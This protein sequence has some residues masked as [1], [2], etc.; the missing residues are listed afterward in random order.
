MRLNLEHPSSV[1]F[2][3]AVS[4]EEIRVGKRVIR[5]SVIIG[6]QDIIPDWPVASTQQI[7]EHHLAP[8]LE[9]EP[10]IVLLGTGRH[11]VFPGRE[12]YGVFLGRRIGLEVMGTAA[13]CRTFNVLAGEGRMVAA[14]LILD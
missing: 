4:P 14:A 13:A 3:N 10:E 2:I 11:L 7:S 12:I 6:T 8:V 9:L 5:G 1:N